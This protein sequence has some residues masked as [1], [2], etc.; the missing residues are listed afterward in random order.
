MITVTKKQFRQIILLQLVII[1]VSVI[2]PFVIPSFLDGEAA[3]FYNNFSEAELNAISIVVGVLSIPFMVWAIQNTIAF[4]LFR[5]YA[6]RHLVYVTVI[7][8]V[9]GIA[10]DPL[11]IVPITS[12][13]SMIV[14][15]YTLLGGVTL[16]LVF[17]SNVAD[18]FKVDA[19]ASTTSVEPA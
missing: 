1:V 10:F 5:P 19:S 2:I 12:I 7:G 17:T 18:F 11:S 4:Y 8:F 14:Y 6:P 9:I 13:E 15:A 3:E 16:A